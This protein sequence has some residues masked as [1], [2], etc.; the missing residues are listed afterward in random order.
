MNNERLRR[1]YLKYLA[2]EDGY[3]VS[4]RVTGIVP[5]YMMHDLNRRAVL[6]FKKDDFKIEKKPW[7]FGG[8]I[9]FVTHYAVDGYFRVRTDRGMGNPACG[10][11]GIPDDRRSSYAKEFDRFMMAGYRKNQDRI[12]KARYE[13]YKKQEEEESERRL[14]KLAEDQEYFNKTLAEI[15]EETTRREINK[16]IKK[17]GSSGTKFFQMLAGAQ[18]IQT[19]TKQHQ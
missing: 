17:S 11:T 7:P 2:K 16:K 5:E 8:E 1:R 15:H 3:E 14:K 12:G 10:V 6:I 19:F 4:V 13:A 9:D 18:A